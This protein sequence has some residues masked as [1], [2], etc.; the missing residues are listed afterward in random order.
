MLATGF[1]FLHALSK[2]YVITVRI[3]VAYSHLPEKGLVAVDLP[4]SVDA[5]VSGSGF[6]LFA[7]QWLSGTEPLPLDF[8][9]SRSVGGGNFALAT[10]QHP[11][12]VEGVVGHGLKVLSVMPD[13]IILNFAGRVE[14]KVPVRPMVTVQCAPL[15]RMGDSI[16]TYPQFV[17]I[18]GAEALVDRVSYL[19]TETK[20]YRN[21]DKAVNEAI[22]LKIPPDLSQLIVAPSQVNLV[23]PVGKY[24]EK[25]VSVPVETINVPANSMVK[26]FPD[27]VDIV[28]E[29][30]VGD[31]QN[32]SAS[33]F[34]VVADYSKAKP[35][36]KYL[37]LEIV[38]RPLNILN[39][40][41]EPQKVDY[42]I[43]K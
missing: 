29:V 24:T 22:G 10:L 1:W 12:R 16:R 23:I 38:R 32:V 27:K 14:K 37:Q 30:P 6:S 4:D 41:I 36:D 31:Y 13:T 43:R 20:T 39:P 3:P 17:T 7:Y 2:E 9:Q 40:R 21:V 8:R 33:M 25:R 15:C 35:G 34:R 5:E 42:L 19:E 18:S 11:D 28:F 26:T